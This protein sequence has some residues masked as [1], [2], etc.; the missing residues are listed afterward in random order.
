LECSSSA[1]TESAAHNIGG[2]VA[3]FGFALYIPNALPTADMFLAML[4]TGG[5]IDCAL[6]FRNSDDR[7]ILSNHTSGEVVAGPVIAADTWYWI[8]G[9][10]TVS[11]NP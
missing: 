9:R 7:L 4:V 2:T 10:L 8:D 5:T 11:A 3:V 6:K 1:A